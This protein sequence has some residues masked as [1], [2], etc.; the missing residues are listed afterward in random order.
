MTSIN[1]NIFRDVLGIGGSYSSNILISIVV[2]IIIV[3]HPLNWTDGIINN[4]G[5]QT[6]E[7]AE[8]LSQNIKQK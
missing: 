7:H 4:I 6:C 1:P 2:G 5:V 8:H 3:V